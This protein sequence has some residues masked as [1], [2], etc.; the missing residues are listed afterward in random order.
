MAK[1]LILTHGVT[2][3]RFL[4]SDKRFKFVRATAEGVANPASPD[5][6][7]IT[8]KLWPEKPVQYRDEPYLVSVLRGTRPPTSY[9]GR[10]ASTQDWGYST[11]LGIS[12]GVQDYSGDAIRSVSGP[13]YEPGATAEGAKSNQQFGT[14]E[15]RGDEL[16]QP[17]VFVFQLV[18]Q[19]SDPAR[20]CGACGA[21][22]PYSFT[23]A[24]FCAA[25]GVRK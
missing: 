22:Y 7:V 17:H 23:P 1:D 8:V 2:L 10:G 16:S 25:C 11:T 9:T 18:G 12:K 21:A 14:T 4:D 3:E 13:A 24:K 6:G 15:W 19:A 20:F 5:N